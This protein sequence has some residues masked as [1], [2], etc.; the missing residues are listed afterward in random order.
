[1]GKAVSS[2]NGTR[3]LISTHARRKLDP[4]HT[5]HTKSDSKWKKD[6]NK[7]PETAALIEGKIEGKVP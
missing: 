5:S 4:Y 6:L 2:I 7:R 1:M 3:K